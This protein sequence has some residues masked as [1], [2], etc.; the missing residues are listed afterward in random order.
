MVLITKKERFELEKQ[1][2]RMG[3]DIF[4]TIGGKKTYYTSESPKVR[5]AIET[6]RKIDWG[7][8]YDQD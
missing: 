1:G 3:K 2:F 4:H 6:L 8:G 7:K 5:V